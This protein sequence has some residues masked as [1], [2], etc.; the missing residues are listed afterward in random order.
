V[1]VSVESWIDSHLAPGCWCE[2]VAPNG[3][4]C[5]Q[6]DALIRRMAQHVA[7]GESPFAPTCG[8]VTADAAPMVETVAKTPGVNLCRATPGEQIVDVLGRVGAEP[9]R[10][11]GLVVL[12]ARRL[13]VANA[14]AAAPKAA[15]YA[16]RTGCGLVVVV[17]A[18]QVLMPPQRATVGELFGVEPV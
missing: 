15:E 12:D 18:G 1:P 13:A 16:K 4:W 11:F 5:A 14:F 3:N 2:I 7:S 10:A 6:P 8:I 17:R 9:A